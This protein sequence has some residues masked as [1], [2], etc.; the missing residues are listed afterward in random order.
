MSLRTSAAALAASLAFLGAQRLACADIA[1][2]WDGATSVWTNASHWSTDPVFPNNATPNFY[3]VTINAGTVTLDQAISINQL[4]FGGGIL[5]GTFPLSAAEGLQWTDGIIAGS[6]LF[7][8]G[9]GSVS[10]F[11][12]AG[13]LGLLVRTVE[14]KGAVTF[15]TGTIQGGFGAVINN[16]AGATF[17]ALNQAAFFADG[18]D[19][20]WTFNNAGSFIARA[21]SGAGF[22]SMDATF[23][24]SGTVSVEVAGG[25]S[26]T[27]QFGAGG[28]HSGTFALAP[29][30]EVTFAG[31]TSFQPGAA[32]TGTGVVNTFGDVTLDTDL[33]M[34]N[35]NVILGTFDVATHGL[36]IGSTAAFD[37]AAVLT[38]DIG[39]TNAGDFGALTIADTALL[40]GDLAV[41][42]AN[43]FTPGG[44][45]IFAIVTATGGIGGFFA[46]VPNDG[47]R[48]D[49]ADGFGSFEIDYEPGSV[50]LTNF[51]PTA[52]PEPNGAVQMLAWIPVLMSVRLRRRII[53]GERVEN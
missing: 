35:L 36:S 40:D 31:T 14:Q 41:S 50:F 25:D 19:P 22:T 16:E 29:D 17:T 37:A 1:A 33:G 47:D 44:G 21:T 48:F 20:A 5:D 34:P 45:D 46:N 28:V 18:G 3:D 43:G 38:L 49:T 13:T 24:N 4:S 12:S 8:L 30:T 39:G 32:F 23:N 15:S 52:I 7:T 6:G 10:S 11:A 53:R 27:L 42:L 9:T 2:T 26:H 51:I